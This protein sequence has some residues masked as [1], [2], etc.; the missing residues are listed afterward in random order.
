MPWGEPSG[1]PGMA[2]PMHGAERGGQTKKT[3][4]A[5][6]QGFFNW[7]AGVGEDANYEFPISPLPITSEPPKMHKRD[8][9][10][11]EAPRLAGGPK[12]SLMDRA[13]AL[14]NMRGLMR[15]RDPTDIGVPRCCLAHMCEEGLLVK[16]DMVGIAADGYFSGSAVQPRSLVVWCVVRRAAGGG[17]QSDQIAAGRGGRSLAGLTYR[18]ARPREPVSPNPVYL[19]ANAGH[20]QLSAADRSTGVTNELFQQL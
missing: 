4:Q 3:L 19:D 7:L 10:R 5:N 6:L 20:L 1:D 18:L 15:T 14:V 12:S 11:A 16:S 8:R 2:S 17:E 13:V 9:D